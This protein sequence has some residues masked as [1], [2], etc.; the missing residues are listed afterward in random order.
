MRKPHKVEGRCF[1]LRALSSSLTLNKTVRNHGFT[2]EIKVPGVDSFPGEAA[3]FLDCPPLLLFLV[4][5][6]MVLL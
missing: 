2:E 4:S 6:C 1:V 3:S 5:V